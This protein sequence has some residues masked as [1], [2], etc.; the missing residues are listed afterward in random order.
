MKFCYDIARD[1]MLAMKRPL[2]LVLD[3]SIIVAAIRSPNG[4]S[5]ALVA[6]LIRGRA[7]LLVSVALFLEYEAVCIRPEHWLETGAS[8]DAIRLLLN[9]LLD[10][11]QP[12]EIY[13][14]WRPQLRDPADEMVLEAA[15][16]GWADAIVTFNQRDFGEAPAAFGIEVLGPGE[17]LRRIDQ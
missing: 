7:T 13:Y 5:A 8:E 6:E 3:T 4:A 11:A 16:S 17:A 1:I 2:K 10:M 9:T 15:A 14:Q 12:V